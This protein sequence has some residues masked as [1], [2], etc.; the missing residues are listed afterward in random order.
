[1]DHE[2][3]IVKNEV[4]FKEGFDETVDK[5]L[6]EKLEGILSKFRNLEKIVENN[7]KMLKA[8]KFKKNI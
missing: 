6:D 3:G 7:S 2:L 4:Y 1:M 5:K 8:M